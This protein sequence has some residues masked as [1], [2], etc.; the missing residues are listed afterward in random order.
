MCNTNINYSLL[1]QALHDSKFCKTGEIFAVLGV[2]VAVILCGSAWF[3]SGPI[4]RVAS[5]WVANASM[6]AVVFLGLRLRGQDSSHFG[7]SWHVSSAR[8]VMRGVAVSLLVFIAAMV[9]FMAGAI[10]M[11]NILGMPE[12]ADMSRYDNLRGNLTKTLLALVS[13]YFVSAFAEEM[14]Y[15]GF[16]ITR[17][18]EVASS[19]K[20][21]YFAAVVVSSILFGLI[22]SDWGLRGMVQASFMGLALGASYL[23]IRRN[24]WIM[25]L[26]HG[27]M[28]TILILQMYFG[29]A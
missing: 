19:G 4:A 20:Y 14:I 11:A 17:I 18:M 29:P 25:I 1:G 22:H 8:S 21:S 5:I 7:L 12:P 3:G 24:L 2:G 26:A 27:Y 16:L 9:A 10:L 13:V 23:V 28:D 6:L 15:R